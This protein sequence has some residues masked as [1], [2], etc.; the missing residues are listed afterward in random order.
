MSDQ[1]AEGT[2][3]GTARTE[4]TGTGPSAPGAPWWADLGTWGAV[5][6]VA[7]GGAAAVWMFLGL[8]G[9]PDTPAG[10]YYQI[11]KVVAVGLVVAGTGLLGRRRERG[12]ARGEA[13]TG[14]PERA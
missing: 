1:H 12:T 3:G 5:A 13:D 11:A 10:G 2:D 4:D 14:G 7:G 6:L 8:P 9:T